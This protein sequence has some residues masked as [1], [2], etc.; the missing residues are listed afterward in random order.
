MSALLQSGFTVPPRR[1]TQC[2]GTK[3]MG[4]PVTLQSRS[5]NFSLNSTTKTGTKNRREIPG[6]G[7]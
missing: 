5:L 2:G 3:R 4:S 1:K 7:G 6:G